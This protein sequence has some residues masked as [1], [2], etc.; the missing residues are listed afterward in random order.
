[1]AAAGDSSAVTIEPSS[2]DVVVC[3]TGL[4]ESILAAACAAAGKTVL[5]IDPNPFY[6]SHFSS[7]VPPHALPAFLL[8]SAS[9]P[10][11]TS[12]DAGVIPL[13][14]RSSLYSDI[15]TLGTVPSEGSFAVD[16]VGPRLLY[17]AGE[18]VDLL[19]RSGGGH[20][21]EFKSVDLLYWD[22]GD[23]FPVPASRED[24][25]KTKLCEDAK[26]NLFDKRHLYA[27][28]ELV[29]SHIAAKERGQGKASI[30]EEDL[31]LPF[32]E[33]LK[34]Q[35]LTP[36]MI[37]VVLY[38]IGMSDYDQEDDTA[39][40]RKTLLTTRDGVKTVALHF[41]SI[42]R[43]ANAKGAFIYPMHGHGELPQAFCRFAAVKGALYVLRM[44]V[45]ALLMDKE[46]QCYIGTRL[47]TGQDILCQQLILDPSYKIP[48]LD[49]PS[50][51]ADSNSPRKVARGICIT[52]KSVKQN[53]SNVLV[54]FPPKLQEQQVATLRVLQLISNVAICPPGMFMAYLSIPCVD[55]YMGKLCINKAIEVLFGSQTSDG[56]EGHSEKT[57]EDNDDAKQ[58]LI[59][60]CVYV[61]EITQA[62]PGPILS[63]PMP[64]E[65]LDYRNI[66]ESTEKLF[67][68]IYPNEEFLP[69]NSA[70]QHEDDDSDSAE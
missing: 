29:K 31:D 22:H 36:K 54:V 15:E 12:S 35:N 1:M 32:V 2:F 30:S 17:C 45:T 49:L 9:P 40:S 57:R 4:P 53:S 46:K 65:Y 3:G 43:F 67:A 28:V 38:A 58:G 8:S 14:R 50:G 37:G 47:A 41:K 34:K 44:P 5:H 59:W 26:V 33:F 66:L 39:D 27:F 7:S 23:L 63:C 52:K 51:P 25:F 55:A 18:S 62:K 69:R 19:H 13:Q 42:G 48:S 64:D 56:S 60:K 70:P 16:L 24:I 10:S 21:V 11:T 68:E 61:Q 6:G 20:H